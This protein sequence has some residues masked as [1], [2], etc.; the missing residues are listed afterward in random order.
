MRRE[1]YLL[2]AA[3][4][5]LALASCGSADSRKFTLSS[6]ALDDG[7]NLAQKYAGN[8]PQN[9]NCDGRN[10]SIPLEWENP[11]PDTKSFVVFMSD[12]VGRGGLGIIHWIAY[13]IPPSKRAFVEGEANHPGDF[14]GGVNTPGTKLYYGPCP[15]MGDQPHPYTIVLIAT[16]I[17]VGALKPGMAASELS[18]ALNGHTLASTGFVVNY[19]S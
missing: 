5:A 15:P 13:D 8:D 18:A 14:I 19:R 16:D 7:G 1:C 12:P 17:P 9:K 6:P 4:T 11:P 2:A 3:L 10:V